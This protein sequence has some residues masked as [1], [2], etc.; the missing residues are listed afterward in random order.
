MFKQG[1]QHVR[2]KLK[3]DTENMFYEKTYYCL[4]GY[5]KRVPIPKGMC[6][7]RAREIIKCVFEENP[8]FFQFSPY[9]IC[10]VENTYGCFVDFCYQYDKAEY[11]KCEMMI[12]R[13]I[14]DY[15]QQSQIL[16]LDPF[17]K[18]ISIFNL[19]LNRGKYNQEIK[20]K[21]NYRTVEDYSVVG[22]FRN[23]QAV[24]Y[25]FAHAFK[26]LC[27]EVGIRCM[28]IRGKL[29][30]TSNESHAWNL[31]ECN[32]K[33]YHIDTTMALDKGNILERYQFFMVD[34]NWISKT[35]TI[36]PKITL[37]EIGGLE[38]SVFFQYGFHCNTEKEMN[39]YL[40]KMLGN[41][42]EKIIL[43][44]DSIDSKMVCTHFNALLE[45]YNEKNSDL[46]KTRY[47]FW[48]LPDYGLYCFN[49]EYAL[50]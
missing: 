31:V 46:P 21:P 41:H 15:I 32:H 39:A 38:Y 28:I 35:R 30:N 25:G 17:H 47:T 1:Y 22:L 44:I 33:F 34:S 45:K 29:S 19:I 37:P 8:S 4:K 27:D 40:K 14:A 50:N 43:H 16:K 9:D 26:L 12:K 48:E 2:G 36:D 7:D 11:N 49:K 23:G 5:E 6:W 20:Q 3:N 24:C 18:I 13:Q 42:K 10:V